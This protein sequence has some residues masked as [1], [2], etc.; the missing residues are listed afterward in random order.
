[1]GSPG[2]RTRIGPAT[3]RLITRWERRRKAE[4]PGKKSGQ[5]VN[6]VIYP[7]SDIAFRHI[8]DGSSNTFLIGE[9]HINAD[10]YRDAVDGGDNEN[11]YIGDNGDINRWTG[12]NYPP[13]QDRPGLSNW[14]IFGSAHAGGLNMAFCDGSVRSISYSIDR[15]THRRLGNRKDGLPVDAE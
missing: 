9:K 14:K 4:P 13:V 6:G 5:L 7:T 1:M 10:H 12:P 3:D 2:L 15:E 11:M 8:T